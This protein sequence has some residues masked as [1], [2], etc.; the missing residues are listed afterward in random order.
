M[1]NSGTTAVCSVK[2]VLRQTYQ[3]CRYEIIVVNDGSTDNSLQIMSRYKIQENVEN[4]IIIDQPNGGPAVARNTGLRIATGDYLCLL[5]SDDEWLPSKIE[6]Q[7]EILNKHPYI[8]FLGCNA[9]NQKMK[10]LG[11]EIKTLYRPTPFKLLIKS[12]PVT[13]SVIFKR[14]VLTDVGYFDDKIVRYAEDGM[15]FL[16]I[17]VKKNYYFSPE[18]LVITGGGK[19]PYAEHGLASNLKGM[20]R[21]ELAV[22][23][24][25]KK[26][27]IINNFQYIFL[28]LFFEIKYI[29]R[30]VIKFCYTVQK[31]THK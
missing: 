21:G 23:M 28:S 4:L 8:D 3:K 15:Y 19:H 22:L 10:F 5:D 18:E 2:S 11:K 26:N 29:R 12:L 30:I 20:H 9:L 24:Y 7:M 16:R 13:P 14:N 17:C 25:A 6:H 27:N 1:Y 31:S